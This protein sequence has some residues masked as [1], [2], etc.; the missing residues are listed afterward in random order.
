[1]QG[2]VV[3]LGQ[4]AREVI[5]RCNVRTQVALHFSPAIHEMAVIT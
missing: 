2:H 4:R 5:V 3:S 1:M